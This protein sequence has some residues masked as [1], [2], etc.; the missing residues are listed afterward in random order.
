M[1]WEQAVNLLLDAAEQPIGQ[2]LALR[3]KPLCLLGGYGSKGR[4][5]PV[6]ATYPSNVRNV[7]WFA[8]E[9]I[10]EARLLRLLKIG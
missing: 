7:F 3:Q 4:G 2:G 8:G 10:G 5:S 1:T 6:R 9:D